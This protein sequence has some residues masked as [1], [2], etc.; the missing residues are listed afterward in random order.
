MNFIKGLVGEL[1]PMGVDFTFAESL[2]NR[3]FG[4]RLEHLDRAQAS[5]VIGHLNEIKAG[6]LTVQQA[7]AA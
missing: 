4:R 2:C 7:L 6:R 3:L 5:T 1:K